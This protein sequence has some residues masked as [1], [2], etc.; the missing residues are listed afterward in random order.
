MAWVVLV[1]SGMME[2]VWATAL[3]K[4]DGFTNP[5]PTI[6][7]FIGLAASMIGLGWATKTLPIGTAYAVWVGIGAALTV[8]YAMVSG[9]EPV[10]V[11]NVVLIT[12]LVGCVVG[13]KLVSESH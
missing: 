5:I 10:S 12:V 13:L 11:A 3:G 2:A 8:I 1:L 7:F 6:V 4:S 9:A